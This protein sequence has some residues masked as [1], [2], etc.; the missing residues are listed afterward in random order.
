MDSGVVLLKADVVLKRKE[1]EQRSQQVLTLRG[2]AYGFYIDRVN[3]K[4]SYGQKYDPPREL[5]FKKE[6]DQSHYTG[7]MQKDVSRMISIGIEPPNPIV[8]CIGEKRDRGVVAEIR[9][10]YDPVEILQGYIL[11]QGVVRYIS[12]IIPVRELLGKGPRI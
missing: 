8:Q 6:N 5:K 10:S 11:D 2:P 7:K 12:F 4:Q 9:L 1:K 3:G